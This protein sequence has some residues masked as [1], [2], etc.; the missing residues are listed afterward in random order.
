MKGPL[1]TIPIGYD[2][3]LGNLYFHPTH[4][5]IAKSEYRIINRIK[6]FKYEK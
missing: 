1:Q 5:K 3:N 2:E 6:F 4:C